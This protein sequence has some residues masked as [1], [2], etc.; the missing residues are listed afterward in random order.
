MAAVA[1]K[2]TAMTL[3]EKLNIMKKVKANPNTT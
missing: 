3:H 1:I 2:Q